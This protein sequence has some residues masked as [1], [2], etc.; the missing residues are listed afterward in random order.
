[1]RVLLSIRPQFAELILSGKKRFEF[2][3]QIYKNPEVTS[4]VIYV[5]KPIGKIVGEF[6]IRDIHHGT[7]QDIWKLTKSASGIDSISY[8]EYF[9]GRDIAFAIEVDKVIK[10]Q[11]PVCLSDLLPSGYPPQS[12][13][14][15][16]S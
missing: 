16:P 9:R 13:A 12:F 1:M 11:R 8:K 2:R 10:Y 4:V 3:R 14:Y 15:L 7:P 5:T 6:T